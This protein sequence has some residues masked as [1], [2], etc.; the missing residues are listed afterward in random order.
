[1]RRA[2]MTLAVAVLAAST[3]WAGDHPGGP[4][5][6]KGVGT[7][8]EREKAAK[9]K[10]GPNWAKSVEEACC[11]AQDRNCPIFVYFGMDN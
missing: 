6:S 3:A 9:P 8:K 1:M 4:S 11:E 7:G 5:T 2:W 10:A